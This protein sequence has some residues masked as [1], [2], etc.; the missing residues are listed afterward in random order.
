V[1]EKSVREKPENSGKGDNMSR[2]SIEHLEEMHKS[3]DRGKADIENL[4]QCVDHNAQ[5]TRDVL[6]AMSSRIDLVKHRE[7]KLREETY[8]A[9]AALQEA[10]KLLHQMI[11]HRGF[12]ID[13]IKFKFTTAEESKD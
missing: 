1:T 3:I 5:Q 6:K 10:N 4:W 13:D 8:Q 9:V 2:E 11:Q 7:D 12:V